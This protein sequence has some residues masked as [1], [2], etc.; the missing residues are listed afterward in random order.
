ME[1]NVLCLFISNLSANIRII[2]QI[3][4]VP[5]FLSFIKLT[6]FKVITSIF[7]TFVT[8]NR[9]FFF[10]IMSIFSDRIS[11][12]RNEAKTRFGYSIISAVTIA[13]TFILIANAKLPT[14]QSIN[15]LM[16]LAYCLTAIISHAIADIMSYMIFGYSQHK[17]LSWKGILNLLLTIGVMGSMISLYDM[18]TLP[19]GTRHAWFKGYDFQ[20][21]LIANCIYSFIVTGITAM[22]MSGSERRYLAIKIETECKE[23]NTRI[24]INAAEKNKTPGAIIMDQIIRIDTGM[25]NKYDLAVCDFIYAKKTSGN[26]VSIAYC[27][28][29]KNKILEYH[30]RMA[31]LEKF[32]IN[33]KSVMRC[34]KNYLI[35]IDRIKS[36]RRNGKRYILKLKG[37]NR[38]IPVSETY[39]RSIYSALMQ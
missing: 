1:F 34:H 9:N 15:M 11:S 19:E 10:A 35:N 26:T 36:T 39:M 8:N 17:F 32:F 23:M 13:I 33:Y 4:S 6:A 7:L 16:I 3:T 18:L 21:A 30:G 5:R 31:A 37:S 29:L 14:A 27:S 2:S 28:G 20:H 25:N 24:A 22:F 12:L 38:E